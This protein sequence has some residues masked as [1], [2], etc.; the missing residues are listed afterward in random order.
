MLRRELHSYGLRL[1]KHI[2]VPRTVTLAFL[3][4][5]CIVLMAWGRTLRVPGETPT[6][7]SALDQLQRGDTVLVDSGVY[8]ES[9]TAPPVSF[10]LRGEDERPV[11]DPSPLAGADTLPSLHLPDGAVA[12]IEDFVFHN[13]RQMYPRIGGNTGGIRTFGDSLILRRC[14]FDSVFQGIYRGDL[15]VATYVSLAECSFVDAQENCLL[16]PWSQVDAEDCLFNGPNGYLVVCAGMNFERCQF[17]GPSYGYLLLGFAGGSVRDC[18][19]GPNGPWPFQSVHLIEFSGVFENNVFTNCAAGYQVLAIQMPCHGESLRVVSNLFTDN[20]GGFA[21]GFGI[22][23]DSMVFETP[24]LEVLNNTVQFSQAN[25]W[26]PRGIGT[27]VPGLFKFNRLHHLE[28]DSPA[29]LTSY[30]EHGVIFS[31]NAIWATGVGAEVYRPDIYP[32]RMDARHNWWGH[33][34]GPS[35]PLLNPFALGDEV[36]DSI[37]F[38]PWYPDTSFLKLSD[39]RPPLATEITIVAFPNPFNALTTVQL[40]TPVPGI[41]R[42][43]LYD[44]LGRKALEVFHGPIAYDKTVV[45]NGSELS[46]G[47]YFDRVWQLTAN[48]TVAATK[49]MLL[50]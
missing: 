19:F 25:D 48:R 16:L 24:E 23:C 36:G 39:R 15:F 43:D 14:D 46:S 26:A 47:I 30:Q 13:G 2:D 35:H 28:P 4:S 45:I 38:D 8:H 10:M 32:Y 11:I 3:T 5:T 1:P 17:G 50:K 44:V 7:Q 21:T 18:S 49:L 37:P 22:G 42:I 12:N 29:A 20:N 33:H 40:E 27:S 9:L 31:E 34:S 41:Y 6:I